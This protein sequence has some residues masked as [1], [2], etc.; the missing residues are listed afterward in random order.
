MVRADSGGQQMSP[1]AKLAPNDQQAFGS[2]PHYGST[3]APDQQIEIYGGKHKVDEQRPIVEIGQPLYVEGPL[4]PTFN[5]VGRKNLV[6]PGFSIF[7]DW[8]TAVAYNNNGANKEVGSIATRL[9]LEADLQ[10]TATER[11]H[12]QF[13]PFDQNTVNGPITHQD[14]FGPDQNGGAFPLNATPRTAFFEGDLGNIAAGL[15]DKYQAFDLPF[16]VGLVPLIFQN[17]IWVNSAMWGG[18]ASI[19]G[20]NSAMFHISNMEFTFFSG[21]DDVTT[22]AV[23]DANGVLVNHGLSAYGAAGFIEANEGYWETGLG[24]IQDNRGLPF[25]ASYGDATI[26]FTRRYGGWLSNS[27]RGVWAFGQQAQAN[28]QHTADGFIL[29]VENSL[30]SPKELVLVPYA[31]A[32]VG[33]GHPQSLM[34]NGDAGG[35]LNNTGITFE[36]DGLTGFPKLDDSGQ[37]TYGGA[38]GV[39]YLFNLDQQI[40]LEASTVQV[41]TSNFELGRQAKGSEYGVGGR[42]QRNLT[43]SLLFRADVIYAEE[44]NQKNVAG[45]RAELRQK[46]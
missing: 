6:Q 24:Y 39:E 5:D 33:F 10:L 7:G 8:R 9:N 1:E 42:Y 36:T 15:T 16:A 22:P 44:L 25:D 43:N 19:I 29:L 32:W 35:I 18:A 41:R 3:Y 13:R 17:G 31:N 21:F 26:A 37:D 12:A 45:V 14:F 4:T 30:I 46:F 28:G 27:V 23:K 38:V 40:V 2:D 20:Q 34:R 11:I